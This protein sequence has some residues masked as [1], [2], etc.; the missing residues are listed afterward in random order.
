MTEAEVAAALQDSFWLAADRLLMFH[1]NPWE[2]DESLEA[3]GYA[4]GPC[5]AMDL[6]GLDV[7]L[8][9]RQ[10]AASPILPRMVAEGRM[11]KKGGVGHYRYPGGGGAVIDPLIEDL[12][13]EEAWFAKVTRHDLSDAELVA[14]MQAA[15][16]A[17]VGRL[18]QQGAD[19]ATLA[20]ACQLAL[21]AP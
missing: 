16:A 18:L 1:T 7:V 11:G 10:G 17:A 15:Q 2:L 6:L 13:L 21:H 14:R 19:R 8:D 5:A 20:R 3:A 12:I 9:R 4:M